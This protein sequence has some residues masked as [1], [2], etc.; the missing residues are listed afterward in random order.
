MLTVLKTALAGAMHETSCA[1]FMASMA[2]FNA[3]VALS[4]S[5][6]RWDSSSMVKDRGN[7]EKAVRSEGCEED[8]ES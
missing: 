5:L 2:A 4:C 1:R 8:S 6:G 7:C 3:E